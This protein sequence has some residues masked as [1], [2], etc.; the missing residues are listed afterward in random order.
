ME[1]IKQF[2][3]SLKRFFTKSKDTKNQ[4]IVNGWYKSYEALEKYAFN[5]V[6]KNQ[7]REN[8]L[9]GIRGQ[10]LQ[11]NPHRLRWLS[12]AAVILIMGSFGLWLV[13]SQSQDKPLTYVSS[14]TKTGM[15]KYLVLSDS[16]EVW[17]NA[18][19]QFKYPTTFAKASRTVYLPQGE[20]F[21]QV[22]RDVKRPF[23]VYVGKLEVRVLGTSFN[24]NNYSDF[25]TQTIVVN[26]GRVQVSAKNK[27]LAVLEKGKQLTYNKTTGVFDVKE[28][29]QALSFSWRDGNTVLQDASFETVATVFKNL[30]GVELKSNIQN[31]HQFS[32]TLTI[33]KQVSLEENL[34]LICKMHHINY[35]KEGSV[36]LLY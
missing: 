2:R 14:A 15:L 5:D 8:L 30:Y 13:K 17:L 34:S 3:K 9:Q 22:K 36:I 24:I 27:V 20:A 23:K 10:M 21:F 29:N 11:S 12:A 18:S 35:R 16:S 26:T 1:S 19:S 6:D 4:Q 33:Q 31:I 25:K 32:Y 28:V 7:V